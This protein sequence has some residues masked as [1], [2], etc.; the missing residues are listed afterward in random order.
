M[1]FDNLHLWEH[2][3][4]FGQDRRRPGELRTIIAIALTG[5]MMAVEIAAGIVFG[6]MALL[7][8][9]LHMT[10][11]TVALGLNA[12]AYIYARRHAHDRRFSFGTGK[13]N[14]LGGFT[15]AILL[16]VFALLMVWG[17]IA[18]VANPV[19]IA[20][21]QAI[22]IAVL[23]LI[24][25][26]ATLFILGFFPTDRPHEAHGHSH[27][28]HHDH[29]L[30]SAYLHVLADAVTSLLAI[31][32]LVLAKYSGF[33]RIDP[34]MGIAGAI[35]VFRWS[36]GLLRTSGSVL[37]DSQG[38]EDIRTR[39]KNGIESDG[40][41]RVADLHLWSIGPDIY[42]AAVSVIAHS[43]KPPEF[44]KRSIPADLGVVHATVEVLT[45]PDTP[46]P[47]PTGRT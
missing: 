47:Q 44:Y 9:G 7:A 15:G 43:P 39:I 38:P 14:A 41:S 32:A 45:C 4:T 20:F 12:F 42:S 46:T 6:S 26:A 22:F 37:L 27:G 17:G 21:N 24:V 10:S 31:F 11:H 1:H 36:G 23:G 30:R 16:A 28:H 34:L 5:S 13:I 2:A 29:N 35:L 25:N 3:H 19:K 18:R 8:D 33:T 40:D